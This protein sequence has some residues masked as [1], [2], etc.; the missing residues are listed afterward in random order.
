MKKVFTALT[1]ALFILCT[2]AAFAEVPIIEEQSIPVTSLRGEFVEGEALVVLEGP[3]GV[4]VADTGAFEAALSSSANSVAASVGAKAMQTYAAIAA[5]SGKNIVHMQADGK[6]TAELLAALEG[7]PG[8]LGAAPNYIFRASVWPNDPLSADLWGMENIKA[9]QAWEIESGDKSVFVAVLDTGINMN[10]E[11]LESNLGVDKDGHLGKNTVTD[12]S[13]PED[14]NGHGT[15][16]AGTI[17]A[18]GNNGVGVVGVNWQVSLLPVKVLNAAGSGTGNQII[19]GLD[20]VLQQKSKGLNIRVA[21]LSLG[22]WGA[23][24]PNFSSDPYVLAYKQLSDANVLIVVAAGNEYQ[25]ID[26]PGGPNSNPAD[27]AMDYR[28]LLPYPACFSFE[29]MLTVAS[30]QSDDK[31]S[32]FSNYSPVYVD[33]AAPGSAIW[34]T[35]R[36]DVD[37]YGTMSGT[38]MATP[39]VAG[40]AALLAARYPAEEAYQ[41]RA[42]IVNHARKNPN[43]TGKVKTG[44]NLDILE[45]LSADTYLPPTPVTSVTPAS[46]SVSIPSVGGSSTATVSFEPGN[47]TNS[48][49]TWSSSNPAVA[50]VVASS[51]VSGSHIAATSHSVT[52]KALS[53][54]TTIITA[55][56][57]DGTKKTASITVTVAAEEAK[58]A[59]EGCSVGVAPAIPAA[60]LL[61]LPLAVLLKRNSR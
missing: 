26:A 40:A 10:H 13:N 34:S 43:L 22:G 15:H 9:P 18:M 12:G 30:V 7:A 55:R 54:G 61:I 14:D 48:A 28:G 21:N 52:I 58:G 36:N 44:G 33:I 41:L 37:T 42:R 51:P 46:P 39:H 29:N 50:I 31:R 6:S 19:A 11:D 2:G 59:V 16:V 5:S 4:S 23:P 57:T 35:T 38:S 1:V 20:Y 25:N 45:A 32:D 3:A 8:V 56:T 53:K 60:L 49:L 47:A 24:V 27:P 17:G